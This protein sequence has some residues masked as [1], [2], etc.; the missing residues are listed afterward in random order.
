[1]TVF[2]IKEHALDALSQME[3]ERLQSEPEGSGNG[4]T[5]S[6][7]DELKSTLR[8]NMELTGHVNLLN[9]SSSF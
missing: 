4:T 7:Y 2:E 6:A 5:F 3:N 1:M 9:Q 8:T